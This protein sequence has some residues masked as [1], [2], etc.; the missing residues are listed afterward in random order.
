LGPPMTEWWNDMQNF[1]HSEETTELLEEQTKELL[2][3]YKDVDLSQKRDKG[4][5]DILKL[6]Q[7]LELD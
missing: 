7:Q 1:Q 2:T 5:V 4:L 3:H 6:R